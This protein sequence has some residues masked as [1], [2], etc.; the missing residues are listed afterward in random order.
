MQDDILGEVTFTV[1]IETLCA[2]QA[3]SLF[4][5]AGKELQSTLT[6]SYKKTNSE[7]RNELSVEEKRRANVVSKDAVQELHQGVLFGTPEFDALDKVFT[8]E[9]CA[10]MCHLSRLVYLDG[11]V[12]A[13]KKPGEN[14]TFFPEKMSAP[15]RYLMGD[16]KRPNVVD[17]DNKFNVMTLGSQYD[18]KN[19]AEASIKV[20]NGFFV[21]KATDMQGIIFKDLE[22]KSVIVTFRGT[23][24]SIR[25]SEMMTAMAKDGII[26]L[27]MSFFSV[28]K[29]DEGWREERSSKGLE[30]P[31][32]CVY[33]TVLYCTVLYCT[34][35]YCTVL[36]CTVLYCTVLE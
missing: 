29:R 18:D 34:V 20:R 28:S 9:D 25:S 12:W 22:T 31:D 15:A 23:D 35:L 32:A 13:S 1:P 14:R 27:A 30:G 5:K 21:D 10:K 8:M 36:F 4:S 3:L 24:F 6:F 26:T 19:S 2:T 7:I 16:F 11:D 33:C 17:F